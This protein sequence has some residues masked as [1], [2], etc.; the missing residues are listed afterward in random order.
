MPET[1]DRQPEFGEIEEI[2]DEV[3]AKFNRFKN[4][5]VK[6]NH[7]PLDHHH[8]D[9]FN[10]KSWKNPISTTHNKTAI[11]NELKTF[12]KNVPS[13]IFARSYKHRI[14]LMRAA[15]I[16]PPNTPFH[17]CLFFFDLKFPEN[18]PEKPPKIHYR[19][20]GLDLHPSLLRT[21]GKITILP[22]SE[23]KWYDRLKQNYLPGIANKKWNPDES[24]NLMLVFRAIRD[25]LTAVKL[26]PRDKNNRKIFALTCQKMMRVL[27]EPPSDF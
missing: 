7:P 27:K 14:D 9:L 2:I 18:Y 1:G 26:E 17:G 24:N 11:Q 3:D 8:Y 6:L 4:F 5:D 22:L 13:W 21:D 10:L 19:P 25:E 16:G 20:Y 15:I 12:A 23:N